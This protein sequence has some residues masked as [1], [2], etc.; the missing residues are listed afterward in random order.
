[1]SAELCQAAVHSAH[2]WGDVLLGYA[3]MWG[4]EDDTERSHITQI[5]VE[6]L[7][8]RNCCEMG[9]H[10]VQ[11]HA[12]ELES[13]ERGFGFVLEIRS[14]YVDQASLELTEIR[15][16]LTPSAGII[17]VRQHRSAWPLS[18]RDGVGP[19]GFWFKAA[20]KLLLRDR[21]T[22]DPYCSSK[23]NRVC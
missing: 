23:K 8:S 12:W 16:P 10:G 21:F 17:G 14:H 15:Q 11:G 6:P 3:S 18:T 7:Y 2:L 9:Y 5:L 13:S 20:S 19:D 22:S 1:M 4:Q